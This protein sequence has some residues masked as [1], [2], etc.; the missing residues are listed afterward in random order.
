MVQ[1]LYRYIL[2]AAFAVL[3]EKMAT[4]AA[5]AMLMAIALQ[6][7]ECASR[8]QGGQG[9]ARGFWQFELGGI[10]G[11]Q[12]HPATARTLKAALSA[13]CYSPTISAADASLA[14]EHNDVLA[15]VFARLLLWTLPGKL[16]A[17][18]EPNRA[19]TMYLAGWRPGKPKPLTWPG[20]YERAWNVVAIE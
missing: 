14:I 4:D 13:L 19:Y 1:H 16:P 8:R 3:P 18:D 10:K 5:E 11:V 2:P 12:T 20:N 6:E 9:P 7:S 17:I 15:C